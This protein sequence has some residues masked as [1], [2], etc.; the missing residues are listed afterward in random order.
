MRNKTHRFLSLLIAVIM[1][2]CLVPAAAF[3]AEEKAAY[4]GDVVTFQ[5]ADGSAFGMWAPQDG[6]YWS[7]DGENVVIHIVPKN[8]STYGWIHWGKIDDEE[9]TADLSKDYQLNADGT[10]DLVLSASEFCG[11]ASPIAPIK[12]KLKNEGDSWT[13]GD[14][15]YLAV[16]AASVY[17]SG[18]EAAAA[19]DEKI[20]AIGEVKLESADAVKQARDAYDAL[21]AAQK[22]LVT[23]YSVLAAAEAKLK[24]LKGEAAAEISK[25]EYTGETVTFIKKNGDAF[26]MFT[27][28]EGTTCK[29]DGDKVVIHYEP[30]NKTTYVALHLGTIYDEELS[31]DI[32]FD[33]NGNFDL[34]LDASEYAGF[35]SP[36]APVKAAY[37][38]GSWTTADQYYL[39]VPSK[40]ILQAEVDNEEA[41]AAVDAK[42]EAMGEVT[43]ES[44][45]AI[46]AA[47]KAYDALTD[48]QKALVKEENV[49]A[50]EA[51]EAKLKELKE[52]KEAEDAARAEVEL[53]VTNKLKM[54]KV[55]KAVLNT[56]EDGS[57]V[58]V[59]SL[60][61]SGYANLFKG[62]Y[63]EAC[64]AGLDESK[65]IKGVTNADGKLE[66]EMPV[67]E[68][69]TYIPVVAISTTYLNKAKAG[70]NK[71]DRAFFPRQFELDETAKTL[72]TDDYS[73][74][75]ELKITNNVK[76]FKP[77]KAVLKTVGGPNSNGYS[78]ILVMTMG[79]DSFDKAFIGR[80]SEAAGAKVLE[81][82]D[83]TVSFTLLWMETP[84]DLDSIT[85]LMAEPIITSWHSAKNDKYYERQFTV[86]EKNG[87]LVIDEAPAEE[88][89]QVIL[90]DIV[91][92]KDGKEV[93]FTKKELDKAAQLDKKT[94]VEKNPNVR[95]EDEIDILWQKD[96]TVPEGTAFP[97]TLNFEVSDVE[98][99]QQ[100]YVYHFEDGEWKLVGTGLNG[101]VSAK[102]E[103][104]S[105]FAVAAK[106]AKASPQTGDSSVAMWAAL[107]VCAAAIG[108]AA[109]I[110]GRKRRDQ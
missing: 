16:P 42:I 40:D 29:L 80:A 36:V 24:E 46:T 28:Q 4:E 107:A 10:I 64:A 66:F 72:V 62:T 71:I 22:Q 48:E 58:L 60:S 23:K 33:G 18:K 85:D 78:K 47:R 99:G 74:E 70:E 11:K 91:T 84:G 92:D 59:F 79:S 61:G 20:N 38:K 49:K 25:F 67:A 76:M 55:V 98:S 53:T 57:K 103:S 52:A 44:E 65:W 26:G 9:N 106:N 105:P 77:E 17:G 73:S 6:T 87:T 100:L 8:T 32:V 5:K 81:I 109:F 7:I 96:V 75:K 95:A 97:V 19:A 37:S 13:T 51:A 27:A 1:V 30:K 108:A 101:K 3:A 56:K 43:L 41:A 15:Y 39:A 94:A 68:G 21:T 34:E 63:E 86:S 31:K 88:E 2:L 90:K 93:S 83:R 110:T 102:V 89:E 12:K 104:M 45:E 69:E 50:L 35:A 82:K 14:Q 54:F